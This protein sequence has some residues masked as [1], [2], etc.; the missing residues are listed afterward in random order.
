MLYLP[1]RRLT[2]PELSAARLDGH[3]IEVGEGYIPADLPEGAGVRAASLAPLIPPR[4]AASGP[5][6]AWVHGAGDRPPGRHHVRRTVERRI[7]VLPQARVVFHDVYVPPEHLVLI[8][9]VAIT[10]PTR[11]MLDLALG[12]HRD[13][14]LLEW[15][16]LLATVVPHAADDAITQAEG[17]TRVPGTKRAIDTLCRLRER[18][19]DVTR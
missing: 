16:R 14:S 18:Q 13:P 1:G 9:G 17:L 10:S 15:L 11:T 7:R 4:T 19:D 2:L 3:V 12:L 6:A 5:S 8:S